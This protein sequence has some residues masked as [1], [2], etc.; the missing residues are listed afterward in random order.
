LTIRAELYEKTLPMNLHSILP[1]LSWWDVKTD[2][3][4]LEFK[5]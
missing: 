3:Y 4:S 2:T 1:F 5:Y